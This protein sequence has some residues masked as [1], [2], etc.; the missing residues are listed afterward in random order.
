MRVVPLENDAI[1]ECWIA[2]RDRFSYEALNGEDRLTA[3]MLKQGGEWKTVDWKTALEYVAHGLKSVKAN[4]GASSIGALVKSH[5]TLEEL[6]LAG[7]FIR[8]QGSENIDFRL[9]NAE[10]ESDPAGARYLGMPISN[11]SVLHSVL[12]VG[13]NLRKDHPLFAQR[14]RQAARVACTVSAIGSTKM[15]WA[16]PLRNICIE[17]SAFTGFRHLRM[18]LQRLLWKEGGS[19]NRMDKLRKLPR[20]LARRCWAASALPYRSAMRRRIIRTLRIFCHWQIGSLA[21]WCIDR[22]FDGSGQ[23]GRR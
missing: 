5:C 10:F 8:G 21:Y 6:Y 14:I 17:P 19:S 15:D 11:L 7:K 18:L 1:N 13:S 3:P 12:V 20:K 16:I 23:Y 4:H 9:R 22:L 2:D